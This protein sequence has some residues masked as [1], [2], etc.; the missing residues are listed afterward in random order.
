MASSRGPLSLVLKTLSCLVSHRLRERERVVTRSFIF[1]SSTSG[2]VTL[3][4]AASP[5]FLP[6]EQWQEEGLRLGQLPVAESGNR[7]F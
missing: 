5:P 7:M 4:A 6:I 1:V 2:T 3:E